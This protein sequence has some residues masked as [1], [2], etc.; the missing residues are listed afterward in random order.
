MGF[1]NKSN[2]TKGTPLAVTLSKSTLASIPS[3]ADDAYFSDP[4]NWK[5]VSV[6]YKN[7]DG[8]KKIIIF[9]ANHAN[10][11]TKFKSSAKARSGFQVQSVL[12]LDFDG[13]Y[14][15]FSREQLNADSVDLGALDV[16]FDA[17]LSL[18]VSL[19]D[20]DTIHFSWQAMDGATSY[21]IFYSP[22]GGA[23][24]NPLNNGDSTGTSK[25]VVVTNATLRQYKVVAYDDSFNQVGSESDAVPFKALRSLGNLYGGLLPD[26][27]S[28]YGITANS[29]NL[30]VYIEGADGADQYKVEWGYSSNNFSVGSQTFPADADAV[31]A[32]FSITGLTGPVYLKVTGSNSYATFSKVTGPIALAAAEP[33]M[34]YAKSFADSLT[35]EEQINE[36]AP[37]TTSVVDGKLVMVTDS[38]FDAGMFIKTFASHEPIN[39][40][41]EFTLRV[42][43]DSYVGAPYLYVYVI[44]GGQGTSV[45]IS[46]EDLAAAM[47]SDGIISKVVIPHT[48]DIDSI[49]FQFSPDDSPADSITIS[50][51]ELEITAN[52]GAQAPAP[53]L[54]FVRDFAVSTDYSDDTL[55]GVFFNASNQLEI[56][57]GANRYKINEL[58]PYFD[59]SAEAYINVRIYTTAPIT[60]GSPSDLYINFTNWGES[61]FNAYNSELGYYEYSTQGG[62]GDNFIEI[63][64]SGAYPA[65]TKITKIEF[66]EYAVATLGTFGP[67]TVEPD[68][69]FS[70]NDTLRVYFDAVEN[71]TKYDVFYGTSADD[72]TTP[73]V[74]DYSNGVGVGMN[75]GYLPN[76][77]AGTTYYIQAKAYGPGGQ[78]V[79]SA[80]AS[81]TTTGSVATKPTLGGGYNNDTNQMELSWTAVPG[82]QNYKL[83][84]NVIASDEVTETGFQQWPDTSTTFTSLGPVIDASPFTDNMPGQRYVYY[85]VSNDGVADSDPSNEQSYFV[86][87]PVEPTAP[88]FLVLSP[89]LGGTDIGVMV[90][91]ASGKTYK[92]YRQ[93]G[94][95]DTEAWG[96]DK[97]I[98]TGAWGSYTDTTATQYGVNYFY[99]I[100]AVDTATS[101]ETALSETAFTSQVGPWPVQPTLENYGEGMF[102]IYIPGGADFP[103][104]AGNI[105]LE[106]GTT[107][108]GVYDTVIELNAS[109][110]QQSYNLQNVTGSGLWVRVSAYSPS[111]TLSYNNGTPQRTDS[112]SMSAELFSSNVI[113]P[114][115][116]T[117]DTPT[118]FTASLTDNGG[119]TGQVDLSWNPT[120]T[121]NYRV[122]FNQNDGFGWQLIEETANTTS[123]HLISAAYGYNY[124][125]TSMD[126]VQGIES[127][128][129]EAYAS[130]YDLAGGYLHI[131]G[132]SFIDGISSADGEQVVAYT[133]NT[134]PNTGI[135]VSSDN[136]NF[137]VR[138]D[139]AGAIYCTY[140]GAGAET[141]FCTL[142]DSSNGQF[143]NFRIVGI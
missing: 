95:E 87:L 143:V 11:N 5:M 64:F 128:P 99:K 135:S 90:G 13:G 32:E 65:G 94:A 100:R 106:Y 107:E 110:V 117:V 26:S 2:A 30:L 139:E 89:D 61:T 102:N 17:S 33:S 105:K 46:P 109:S 136:A 9:D 122:Y 51:I 28:V 45:E 52:P 111:A 44:G 3:L 34:F 85:V 10:P 118:G 119:G 78:T 116:P 91:F 12:I 23:S 132:L 79:L 68:T 6:T 54:P 112:T 38:D 141:A 104:G 36:D 83:F 96:E 124:R 59:P 25:D 137:A 49:Q 31:T 29:M 37:G 76:L 35:S 133:S 4:T 62:G 58:R 47:A 55:T 92:V 93:E 74:T 1:L 60:G 140:T 72:V 41:T 40:S 114:P 27:G 69:G 82:A 84:R 98:T 18:A 108:T 56:G 70:G 80:V 63:D 77:F 50:S 24:W 86:P 97:L 101:E 81:G 67:L 121:G 113:A 42:H 20:L 8:Q 16:S 131:D 127:A 15:I 123:M 138:Y 75:G 43:L 129:A 57:S 39:F 120:S 71:A 125:V 126:N 19:S 103:V 21:Q 48:L 130:G 66:V 14:K 73:W 7:A 53:G 22:D 115:P 142:S 134:G 88:D